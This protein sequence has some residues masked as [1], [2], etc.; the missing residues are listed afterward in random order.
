MCTNV[1]WYHL[2]S[3][4]NIHVRIW[5]FSAIFR[6]G[7]V[8]NPVVLHEHSLAD[9]FPASAPPTETAESRGAL[10][11]AL[12]TK[13]VRAGRSAGRR[14]TSL[15]I[16]GNLTLT[17]NAESGH[18]DLAAT[19]PQPSESRGHCRILE[20]AHMLALWAFCI[21]SKGCS[22]H[23]REKAVE[24]FFRLRIVEPRSTW[25][26]GGGCPY[27]NLSRL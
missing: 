14:R 15:A 13:F 22:S 25:T 19:T 11:T 21:L 7:C 2:K 9:A 1:P 6:F 10:R 12:A 16:L 23:G 3:T 27:V 18:R 20:L 8:R 5:C 17:K 24:N 4:G 26:A